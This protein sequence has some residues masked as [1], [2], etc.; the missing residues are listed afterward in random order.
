MAN[1]FGFDM[2]AITA[3]LKEDMNKKNRSG[4]K[5]SFAVENE[6]KP[7]PE[8]TVVMRFVPS[9]DS[10]PYI[11][12]ATHWVRENGVVMG[13]DC[14]RGVEG[15]ECPIC[16]YNQEVWKLYGGNSTEQR[17]AYRT[18]ALS[19][20]QEKYWTIVYIVRNES[21]PD[22][23]GKF[24]RFL[25]GNQIYDMICNENKETVDP[26]TNETKNGVNVLD[27]INGKDFVYIRKKGVNGGFANVDS[28]YFDSTVRPIHDKNQKALTADEIRANNLTLGEL[29]KTA[30][31]TMTEEFIIKNYA[32]K[33]NKDIRLSSL[34]G[35]AST[36]VP[37]AQTAP[38]APAPSV[39]PTASSEKVSS[40]Q[41]FLKSLDLE[42]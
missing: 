1:E 24:F 26:I 16:K 27:P 15:K 17:T 3:Q 20:A 38:S 30:D 28:S 39:A 6:F 10:Y 5:K 36:P 42:F 12:N 23:E 29:K 18:K 2:G 32:M 33:F 13:Y 19:R 31:N 41:D 25:I 21:Q 9:S 22:T 7:A 34:N 11:K 8:C 4:E 35:S 40:N 14:L 37:S